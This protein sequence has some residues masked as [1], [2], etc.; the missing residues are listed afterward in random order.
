MNALLRTQEGELQPIIPVLTAEEPY[1]SDHRAFYS[2]EIPSVMFSTG[3]YPEHNTGKDTQGIIDYQT[4][5]RELEYV[6]NF[7]V[8]LA[9][10]EMTLSFKASQ[11]S[12]PKGSDDIVSFYDCDQRPLFSNNADPRYFLKE[13]VYHYLRYPQSAV[14]NGI[15]GTVMVQFVIEKDGKVSDVRVVKGV[16]PELDDEA[17]RVIKASPKWKP[18]KMDGNR[19]KAALTL[20]VEFRLEKRNKPSFGIKR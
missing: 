15:Q 20:P 19:V 11:V 7:T 13:W 9:N 16:D 1:P 14:K 4:M 2:K 6:F 12:L 3:R 17:V 8:A 18:G 10:T 5:E